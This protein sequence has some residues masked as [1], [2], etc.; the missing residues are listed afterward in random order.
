MSQQATDATECI[1]ALGPLI[2]TSAA[3]TEVAWA[4]SETTGFPNGQRENRM[5]SYPTLRFLIVWGYRKTTA[6]RTTPHRK[7]VRGRDN[8][9]REL[10]ISAKPDG[11]GAVFQVW[12]AR[13]ERSG[14]WTA[15]QLFPLTPRI[16][17]CTK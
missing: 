15:V 13:G 4:P 11:V 14:L 6:D 12:T 1:V 10:T 16:F 17:R 3:N 7:A 9:M 2:G 8:F 5:W